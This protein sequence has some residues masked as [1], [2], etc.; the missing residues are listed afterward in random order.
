MPARSAPTHST[1]SRPRAPSP[2]L[3]PVGRGG[4]LRLATLL[5]AA[6]LLSALTAPALAETVLRRGNGAEPETLDPHAATGLPEAMIIYDLYE[7]LVSRGPDGKYQPALAERWETAADGLSVTFTL[8][9]GARWSD[10]SPVT[11]DDVVF[12]F[13]RL[14]DPA[15]GSR[16]GHF[17]WP[18]KNAKPVTEGKAAPD[19]LGVA[20]TGPRTVVFTLEQP[21]P[22]L[23][24]L[25]SYPFLVVLPQ[26][27]VQAKGKEFF[28]AGALVSSGGYMLAEQVPQGHVKLV[29]NPNHR[30][31]A[32]TAIDT[33]YFYPTENQD[34]ELKRFRAGEL[35]TTNTLPPAQVQWA[36]ENLK[37]S[38]R[39]APQLGSYYY[40][41]NLTKEPWKSNAKLRQALSMAVDREV[42]VD[43]ITQ[44]GEQALY[45]YVPATV[46]GYTAPKPAWT[47]WPREKRLAEAKR[48]L[49]EAG[50]SGGQGLTLDLL[51]NTAENHRRIAVA[52]ASM[53]QQGL[54]IRATVTN[55]E[56][57]VFLDSRRTKSYP[58]LVRGG[59]IGAYDDPNAFLEFM[60]TEVGPENIPGY[61]NPAYDELLHRATLEKDPAARLALLAQAEKL[62]LDEAGIIPL[63]TYA[64]ARLVSPRVKGWVPNP[65]DANASRFLSVE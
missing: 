4:R 52:L 51:Y 28:R 30:D 47:G 45:S 49:A 62:L 38:F 43:R 13:R 22:Y 40:A 12:S 14:V 2:G 46:S 36:R 41:P 39:L 15:S 5:L 55:Q 64:R 44:G 60:R 33:V 8:R 17:L 19:T 16:N 59:L 27:P 42:L 54:G 65:V 21:T 3:S 26:G 57:K 56:W 31:A 61:T 11:A 7:G 25:L 24:S 63:Y 58:G 23:V 9:E 32:K 1:A 48:L 6:T 18:V 34:T 29:R 50:Y 53:W 10:G 20:A 37:D 35:D